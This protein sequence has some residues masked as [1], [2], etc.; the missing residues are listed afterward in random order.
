MRGRALPAW[1]YAEWKAGYINTWQLGK[2]SYWL[3]K[4]HLGWSNLH[5]ALAQAIAMLTHLSE[6]DFKQRVADFYHHE[7]KHHYRPQALSCIRSF[8]AHNIPTVLLTT[9]SCYLSEHVKQDLGLTDF[10]ANHFEVKDGV[11]T[12]QST[13]I[14]CFAEG[15][16]QAAQ[17]Y[18]Q[19]HNIPL[20]SCAFY[21]DS[22]SDLAA[23]SE[24]G[25]P[26]VVC[27]DRRLKQWALHHQHQILNWSMASPS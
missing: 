23:L 12:G 27:P 19:T 14:V 3:L 15:K 26:Y 8:Q 21:T 2:A 13:G 18:C 20:Q 16:L 11:F 9:S 5:Q 6:E 25:F 10:L 1:A 4:Y 24:V 7:V 22:Y 17:A